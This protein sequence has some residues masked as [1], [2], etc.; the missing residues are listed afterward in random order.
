[1]SYNRSRAATLFGLAAAM[2]AVGLAVTMSAASAPTA[3]ADAYS[4]IISEVD[5][6]FAFGQTAFTTA[7]T[8]FG[9]NGVALGLTSFFDGV[10]DDALS[11]PNVLLGGSIEALTNEAI[12]PSGPWDLGV[13]TS[14]SDLSA[15]LATDMSTAETYFAIGSAFFDHAEYGDATFFDLFGADYASIIPLEDLILGAVASLY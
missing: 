10:D 14:P 1:M 12:A 9:S 8:D 13:V 11:V 4:D 2:G 7:A 3:H 5:A 6:D 15:A